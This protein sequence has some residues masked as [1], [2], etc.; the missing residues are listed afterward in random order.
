MRIEQ[1]GLEREDVIALVTLH[2]TEA[3]GMAP[4]GSSHAF[5]ISS[6]QRPD[7]TFWTLRIDDA[8]AGC[9]ALMELSPG[10]GELKS[11]RTAAGFTRRGVA[12]RLLEHIIAVARERGYSRISLD[13]GS[14]EFYRPA[15]ELYLS[16]GFREC[17]PFA[18]YSEDPYKVFM[19]L[20]L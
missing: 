6:L 15:R 18:D 8:L 5:D 13:T 10:H 2:V 4:P 9:A 16:A 19:T 20:E 1:G 7:L 17:G 3:R 14:E 11:M 12:R